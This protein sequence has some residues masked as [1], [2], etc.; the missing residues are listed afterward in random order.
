MKYI[1]FTIIFLAVVF[2]GISISV[3]DI[4]APFEGDSGNGLIVILASFC[5]ICLMGILLISRSISKK[6]NS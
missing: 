1:I 3:L 2:I 5:V 4:Q 6:A